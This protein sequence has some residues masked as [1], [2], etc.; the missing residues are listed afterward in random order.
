[1]FYF[2]PKNWGEMIQSDGLPIFSDG[3]VQA[4][5]IDVMNPHDWID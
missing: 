3:L 5:K 2:H 1:M 4:P